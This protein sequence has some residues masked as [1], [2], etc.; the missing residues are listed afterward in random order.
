[1]SHTPTFGTQPS[2]HLAHST[3][4]A[5]FSSLYTSAYVSGLQLKLCSGGI[6]QNRLQTLWCG[7]CPQAKRTPERSTAV[8]HPIPRTDGMYQRTACCVCLPREPMISPTWLCRGQLSPPPLHQSPLW[9]HQDPI[10]WKEPYLPFQRRRWTGCGLFRL[11]TARVNRRVRGRVK[12][13]LT[14][15][16]DMAFLGGGREVQNSSRREH[17]RKG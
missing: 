3:I 1:M 8:G 10:H 14:C 17:E 7:L 9:L 16:R 2:S 15:P 11:E 12:D 4:T 5:T 13:R 6:Q